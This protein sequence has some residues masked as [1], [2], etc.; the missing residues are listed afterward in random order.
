LYHDAC[1]F[2][3]YVPYYTKH[4]ASKNDLFQY[5]LKLKTYVSN[6]FRWKNFFL[7]FYKTIIDQNGQNWQ[8]L[9]GL[10]K[11]HLI[12]MS[13]K[14]YP[15]QTLAHHLNEESCKW[16]LSIDSWNL[17]EITRICADSFQSFAFQSQLFYLLTN[18]H[19]I[20]IYTKFMLH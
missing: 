7:R 10:N 4:K 5:L 14:W 8:T 20:H 16:K 6:L 1:K 18:I 9:E 15:D 13:K 17:H 2:Q 19:V 3:N 11:I 12:T